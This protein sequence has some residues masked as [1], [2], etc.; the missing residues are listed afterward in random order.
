MTGGEDDG[1]AEVEIPLVGG[2]GSGGLVVRV[3]D[4]I[5]RP[6]VEQTEATESFLRHLEQVG[7]DAAPRVLGRDRRGR[8]I[9]SWMPGEVAVPPYPA[10]AAD[11]GLLVSVAELQRRLHEASESFRFDPSAPWYRPNLPDVGPGAIVGHNDLCI[12]NVVVRD[13]RAVAFID[14]DFAAPTDRLLDIAIACRHWVPLKHPDDLPPDWPFIDQAHRFRRFCNAHG[15]DPG[16]R[17]RV[18]EFALDFLDRALVT[19][20][21]KAESGLALYAKVWESGYPE[22][23][24][25]SHSWLVDQRDKGL[26]S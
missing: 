18:V 22:Q 23:N 10:W 7:F 24:R 14:F 13:G 26:C 21:A 15:L 20:R 3:G 16:E 11:E 8:S 5:R 12:E 25:R 9:L 6:L 17:T 19:M 2:M 4:T 1:P